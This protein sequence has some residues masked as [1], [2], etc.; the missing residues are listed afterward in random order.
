M[1]DE[2]GGKAGLR[3]FGERVAVGADA[4]AAAV[5]DQPL[6]A[7]RPGQGCGVADRD[8]VDDA[9]AVALPQ[10]DLGAGAAQRGED[11]ERGREIGVDA[12]ISSRSCGTRAR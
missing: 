3:Q 8:F 2:V 10:P 11:P 9:P 1:D 7:L 12:A 5:D 6:A 4:P